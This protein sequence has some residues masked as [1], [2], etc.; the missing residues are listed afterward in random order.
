MIIYSAHTFATEMRKWVGIFN[1]EKKQMISSGFHTNSGRTRMYSEQTKE[2]MVA[3]EEG[4][5]NNNAKRGMKQ[6]KH[7][8]PRNHEG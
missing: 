1:L 6:R 8:I 4:L 2:E 3:F 5:V 7:G